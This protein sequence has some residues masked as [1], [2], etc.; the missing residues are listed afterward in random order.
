[1]G[2]RNVAHVAGAPGVSI[3]RLRRQGYEDALRANNISVRSEWVIEGGFDEWHG[4]NA[5]Q[6]LAGLGE[7]PDAI[8][9]VTHPTAIGIQR[10]MWEMDTDLLSKIKIAAF[11]DSGFDTWNTSP[12][13]TIRQPTEEMGRRAMALLLEAIDAEGTL[14]PQSVVLDTQFVAPEVMSAAPQREG[15]SHPFPATG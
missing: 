3:T 6:S 13:F 4:Y 7:L 15:P 10:A 1:M 2:Y 12:H 9:A 14:Q 5:F 11:G 8:F